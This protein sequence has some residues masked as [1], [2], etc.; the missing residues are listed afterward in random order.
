MMGVAGNGIQ[1]SFYVVYLD[2][3]GFS[4][5]AISLLQAATALLALVGA[6]AAGRFA[7]R[8]DPL[9]LLVITTVGE[10]L[11]ITVTPLFG[12][13]LPLV[14]LA[15]FRGLSGGM[16]HPLTVANLGRGAEANALG[17]AVGLRTTAN[18]FTALVT[19]VIMGLVVETAGLEPSFF[20]IG[21]TVISVLVAVW[22]ILRRAPSLRAAPR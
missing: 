1:I 10:I 20:V 18:R 7:R 11:A 14:L 15:G 3:I 22:L 2:G 17:K 8:Y 9:M 6:L 21:G 16:A 5:T 4:A 13:A 19:P 12:S